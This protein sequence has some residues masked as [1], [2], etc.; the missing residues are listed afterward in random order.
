MIAVL[1]VLP[2]CMKGTGEGVVSRFMGMEPTATAPG[3]NSARPVSA[4][5]ADASPIIATLQGRRSAISPGTPYARVAEAVIASD[6]RVA[7]AELRVAR[8]RAEAA[9]KNWLPKIG[10]SVSLNSLGEFVAELVIEQVLF[11]NGRKIAERDKAKADVEVAAVAL[12]E[13]GNT[14]VFEALSLYLVAEEGREAGA[15]FARAHKDMAQFEWVMNERVAGGVSDMSDLNVLRQKLASIMARQQRAEESTRTALAELNAMSSRRLDELRGLGDLRAATENAPLA[16]LRAEAEREVSM[17]EARILR[18]GHLPGLGA[19]GSV[20]KSGD[21]TG[22]LEITTDSL[23]GLGTM[24]EL[25][26]IEA[27][28]E[29]ADR[30]VAQARETAE[31]EIAS[32]SRQI[33]AYR[34]Q[35]SE[36]RLLTVQAKQN[37]DLFQ[38]QYEGGQRQVMDVVGVYETYASALETEIDLR[39][40]A[41]RSELE[42]ARLKGALAEGAKI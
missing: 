11:D 36:A 2:G 7:E 8:L 32:Q 42:L 33:E 37:L 39:Y 4:N 13:D 17:A 14:R 5:V 35:L 1:A 23:F 27:G 29:S 40:Q 31:R 16:V 20:S 19:T 28:K 10:P 25:N 26:A 22:G 30:R 6:A 38:R 15:H 21:V 41:A 9:Q 3:T 34:R 12:V 24:A 18:A